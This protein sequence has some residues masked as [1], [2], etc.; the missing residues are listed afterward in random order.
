MV[1][2]CHACALGLS[3]RLTIQSN[4]SG[5]GH[6]VHKLKRK[7]WK[8][9]G[10]SQIEEART[11]TSSQRP[12]PFPTGNNRDIQVSVQELVYGRKVSGVGTSGKSFNR[13]NELISS[14]EKVH[15][16]RNDRG[17][18]EGLNTHVFQRKISKDKSLV[19]KPKHFVRGPE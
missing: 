16:P 10:E 8:P 14:C 1:F 6:S 18:S 15:E 17:P 4:G 19:E 3:H 2:G 11:S 5:P 7:E 9:R 13:H 12:E